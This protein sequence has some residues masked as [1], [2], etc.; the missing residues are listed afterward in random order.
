M[1]LRRNKTLGFLGEELAS[2]YLRSHGLTIVERNF[3]KRYS[4]I[5]IVAIDGQTLVFV[6][7]KT[8]IGNKFGTPEESITPWK[9]QNLVR[10]ANFYKLLHPKSPESLRIDMVS[11]VLLTPERI[12]KITWYKNITL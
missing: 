6:E 12:D 4:E 7:V 3:H 8:R 1:K 10:S 9:M 5:D 2:K 11:V